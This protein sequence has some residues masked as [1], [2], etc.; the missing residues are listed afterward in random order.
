MKKQPKYSPEVIE[1]G[2]RMVGEVA[3]EYGSQWAAIE[4]IAAKI[5]CAGDATAL[6]T[7]AGTRHRAACWPDY[8]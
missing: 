1:R 2:V 5:G 4:S 6:G 7:A 3:S 8:C